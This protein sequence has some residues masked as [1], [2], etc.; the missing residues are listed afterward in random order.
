MANRVAAADLI[1]VSPHDLREMADFFVGVR[2]SSFEGL[3]RVGVVV[4]VWASFRIP[5]IY[6]INRILRGKPPA[7]KQILAVVTEGLRRVRE[8]SGIVG[9]C[10]ASVGP[11]LRSS[12]EIR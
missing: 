2:I 6:G 1:A 7:P 5:P 4:S 3:V 9:N 12:C 10:R 8:S 11:S